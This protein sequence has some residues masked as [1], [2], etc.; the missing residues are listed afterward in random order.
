MAHVRVSNAPAACGNVSNSVTTN[1]STPALEARHDAVHGG[2]G[3][4]RRFVRLRFPDGG[5]FPIAGTVS[6]GRVLPAPEFEVSCTGTDVVTNVTTASACW[7]CPARLRHPA[8]RRIS[9]PCQSWD[10]DAHRHS[11]AWG[12]CTPCRRGRERLAPD[13]AVAAA[14]DTAAAMR[15]SV[16][17]HVSCTVSVLRLR[18]NLGNQR[19]TGSVLNSFVFSESTDYLT[20]PSACPSPGA[21]EHQRE[22]DP[23]WVTIT[24]PRRSTTSAAGD[25]APRATTRRR[26]RTSE[27]STVVEFR[28]TVSRPEVRV[29]E[30]DVGSIQFP[31]LE[32]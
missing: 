13:N 21:G 9:R 10:R 11:L 30:A 22:P 32:T 26:E 27:H 29:E 17:G 2:V 19:A 31:R 23:H 3:V 6:L 1:A 28:K 12:T 4:Q 14:G 16:W 5:G 25:R 24:R 8:S 7:P 20:A 18:P 15:M